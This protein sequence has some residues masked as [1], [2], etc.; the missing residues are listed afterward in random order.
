MNQFDI[1]VVKPTSSGPNTKI[2]EFDTLDVLATAVA[3]FKYNGGYF[4]TTEMITDEQDASKYHYRHSNKDILRNQFLLDYY[5]SS[6]KPPLMKVTDED[7]QM[8]NDI[9]EYSKKEIFKCI[10]N[11]TSYATSL[12]QC[13]NKE[14]ASPQDFGFIA[15]APFYYQNSKNKDF[16]NAKMK[17]IDGITTHVGTTG[18]KIYLDNFEIIRSNKSN[19]YPGWV[20]M[21]VCDNNLFLFFTRNH[22]IGKRALGD[23]INIEG[24]IKDHIMEKSVTPMTKLNKV[25]ERTPKIVTVTEKIDDKDW[26]FT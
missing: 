26:A 15:S 12:Y 20:V 5:S 25:Y 17:E 21:G 16:F 2:L 14:K 11:D 22:F 9:R 19:N 4:K 3:A 10:A 1:T 24:I 7:H 23:K 8:A 13:L 6:S 18:A